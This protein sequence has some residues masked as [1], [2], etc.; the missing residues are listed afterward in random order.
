MQGFFVPGPLDDG[1]PVTGHYFEMASDDPDRAQV[2]GYAGTISYRPGE[3]MSV[4]GMGKA[5]RARLEIARDGLTPETVL[6]R[7]IEVTFTPAPADCSVMGC[8]WPV[9]FEMLLPEGWRSGV[10]TITLS[11]P[12]HTSQSMFVLRP[13][14]PSANIA[15]VLATGTWCA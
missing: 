12:G 11:V 8:D 10:Y 13:A 6:D 1:D 4:H 7:E 15:F 5:G 2:W 9:V 14:K 3:M